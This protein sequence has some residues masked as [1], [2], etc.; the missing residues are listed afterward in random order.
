MLI[1]TVTL[2]PGGDASRAK[3]LATARISNV[4]DLA[5][6][7][8]YE[9]RVIEHANPVTMMGH[10]S[11]ML[12]IKEHRRDQ[13]VWALVAEVADKAAR[14]FSLRPVPARPAAVQISEPHN[15][16]L[17]M[18][19]AGHASRQIVAATGIKP[20]TLHSVLA[21]ARERGDARGVRRSASEVR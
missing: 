16:A 1:V 20:T 21:S 10:Q 12:E 15:R 9:A 4:S 2:L 5:V 19:A 7:S 6:M 13:S 18:W 14:K 3:D 8:D 11:A 17:D